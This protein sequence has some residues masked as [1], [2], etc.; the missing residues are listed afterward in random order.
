MTHIYHISV[1][2]P[3]AGVGKHQAGYA[4]VSPTELL[5]I[6]MRSSAAA[7]KVVRC[8]TSYNIPACAGI[9]DFPN[10]SEEDIRKALPFLKRAGVPYYVHAEL[11]LD[12]SSPVRLARPTLHHSQPDPVLQTCQSH[13]SS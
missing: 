12:G 9:N 5:V 2:G 11:Q 13:L 1:G 4:P 3:Q 10:V 7:D 8:C 6:E